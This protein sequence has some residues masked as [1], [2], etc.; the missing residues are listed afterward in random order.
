[1]SPTANMSIPRYVM[2]AYGRTTDSGRIPGCK[3]LGAKTI[4]T[5][6]VVLTVQYDGAFKF[7]SFNPVD[8]RGDSAEWY[9]YHDGIPYDEA[10]SM[11][12][13]I[14]QVH[15]YMYG[16]EFNEETCRNY[17]DIDEEGILQQIM[18]IPGRYTCFVVNGQYTYDANSEYGRWGFRGLGYSETAISDLDVIEVFGFQDSVGLDYYTYFLRPDGSWLRSAHVAPGQPITMQHEGY[19]FVIGGPHRH[20]DRIE[21]RLVAPI[22]NSKLAIVDPLTFQLIDIA[23]ATTDEKGFVTFSIDEPG[24]YYITAYQGE[25]PRARA[26]LSLP[27][28]PVIVK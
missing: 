24:G 14:T 5:A 9:G 7:L 17:L 26:S 27:C 1:M 2:Q 8:I 22:K 25:P 16:D 23:D 6:R 28:L 15:E 3:P 13:V 19:L 20:V 11:L 10:P 18:G 12:D 21:Q 4:S